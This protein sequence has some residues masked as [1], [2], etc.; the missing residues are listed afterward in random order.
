MRIRTNKSPLNNKIKKNEFNRFDYSLM[1]RS[2]NIRKN[3][4][5]NKLTHYLANAFNMPSETLVK[6]IHNHRI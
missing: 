1:R 2:N 4:A 5:R 3:I 6:H